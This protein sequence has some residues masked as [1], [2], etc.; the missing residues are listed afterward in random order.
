MR[1]SAYVRVP[2]YLPSL[3]LALEH[4]PLLSLSPPP[5][6]LCFCLHQIGV[7]VPAIL[8]HGET[9]VKCTPVLVAGRTEG[10]IEDGCSVVAMF[11]GV[12]A[13]DM[14]QLPHSRHLLVVDAHGQLLRT[15]CL[16]SEVRFV[17]RALLV[18]FPLRRN[19]ST[20]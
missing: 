1:C 12:Q 4:A 5:F 2:T 17:H 9:K 7:D 18:L 16:W 11:S 15:V 13:M 6:P 19:H 20:V 14:L 8:Q 10:D 3:Q